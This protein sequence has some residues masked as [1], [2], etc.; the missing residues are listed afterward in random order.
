MKMFS[1][2]N[3]LFFMCTSNMINDH[4]TVILETVFKIIVDD[5]KEIL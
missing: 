4:C 2:S 1:D 5:D 3:I